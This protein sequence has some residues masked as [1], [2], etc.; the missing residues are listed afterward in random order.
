MTAAA[1]AEETG[2]SPAGLRS[3]EKTGLDYAA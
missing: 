3:L 1:L 2:V